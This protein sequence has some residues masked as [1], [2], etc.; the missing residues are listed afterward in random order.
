MIQDHIVS[1]SF[2][3]LY[4]LLGIYVLY[5]ILLSIRDGLAYQSGNAHYRCFQV[6]SY[7]MLI[8]FILIAYAS[9][10]FSFWL[11]FALELEL[12]DET[13]YL[14][15]F[16]GAALQLLSFLVLAV[17]LAK[18]VLRQKWSGSRGFRLHVLLTFFLLA[19]A[20]VIGTIILSTQAAQ[21]S[22]EASISFSIGSSI[23]FL[24]VG[25]GFG[26]LAIML[27]QLSP[28]DYSRMLLF[29]P[30][31]VK[32]VTIVL[33][34][35]L[36]S[37]GIFDALVANGISS[38]DITRSDAVAD[39]SA[40]SAYFSWEFFPIF[41]LFATI[42]SRPKTELAS[43][44]FDYR[45]VNDTNVSLNVTNNNDVELSFSSFGEGVGAGSHDSFF[46][47]PLKTKKVV[48]T[49]NEGQG[50]GV[51]VAGGL[52]ASPKVLMSATKVYTYR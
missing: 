28:D 39:A 14:L 4:C 43:V 25:F 48:D 27:G 9:V 15:F 21:G 20:D 7:R 8:L 37:R 16:G 6:I 45:E 35:V 29:H 23:L 38:I 51:G 5:Q 40:I 31:T 34:L 49:V 24:F 52:L 47:S 26:G 10:R 2:A 11:A 19:A 30:H 41:L 42:A 12:G 1:L 18:V 33:S 22:D 50:Q 46:S 44:S 13:F 3:I 17:F 32:A 36:I